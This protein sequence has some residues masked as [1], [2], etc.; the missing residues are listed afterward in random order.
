MTGDIILDNNHVARY[1]KPVTVVNGQIQ[2]S[3]FCLRPTEGYLSVSCLEYFNRPNRQ[4]EISALRQVL[5]RREGRFAVLNVGVTKNN[6]LT[7]SEDRRSISVVHRPSHVN[8]AHS[9]IHNMRPNEVRIA[10]LIRQTI[11]EVHSCT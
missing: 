5:I 10:E 1:C 9:G 11:Q 3:A 8:P 2:G 7:Y 6:V 4:D